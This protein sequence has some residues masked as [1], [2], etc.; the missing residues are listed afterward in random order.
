M[1][2]LHFSSALALALVL[3]TTGLTALAQSAAEKPVTPQPAHEKQARSV[4]TLPNG[5]TMDHEWLYWDNQDFM[6]QLGLGK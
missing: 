3:G 6:T 4:E 5:K 2:R 1:T